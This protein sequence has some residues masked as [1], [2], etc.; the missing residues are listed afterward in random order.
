MPKTIEARLSKLGGGLNDGISAASIDLD[1]CSALRNFYPYKTDLKKRLGRK[2]LSD[3]SGSAIRGL[4]AYKRAVGEWRLLAADAAQKFL[5][6]VGDSFE[7]ID[8]PRES[9]KNGDFEQGLSGWT[10]ATSGTGAVTDYTGANVQFGAHCV[11]FTSTGGALNAAYAYQR[12]YPHNFGDKR[13]VRFW[14]KS[15]VG[16]LGLSLYYLTAA[17]TFDSQTV[18]LTTSWAEYELDWDFPNAEYAE[19]KF[20]WMQAGDAYV[21]E[22]TE[23]PLPRDSDE[24]WSFVQYLNTAY[25]VRPDRGG[26]LRIDGRGVHDAGI[27]APATAPTL[28]CYGS[29]GSVEEGDFQG[30]V[31][32][33][34]LDTDTESDPS[35][36][37]AVCTVSAADGRVTWSGIP[38]STSPQVNARRLYRTLP[39]QEG[40]Y[41]LVT[42]IRDN[43]TTVYEDELAIEELGAQASFNNGL[44]PTD[45]LKCLAIWRERLWA[46]SRTSLLF[47]EQFA[48]EGFKAS[49]EIQISPDDGHELVGAVPFGDRLC[50]AK[51]NS[52]GFILGNGPEDFNVRTFE[53][54]NGCIATSSLRS[55]EGLL[56]WY[57]GENVFMSDGNSVR[58]V[59]DPSIRG[60]LDSIPESEKRNVRGAIYPRLGWYLLAV[61]VDPPVE[62][63]NAIR[64]GGFELGVVADV[65]PQGIAVTNN[66]GHVEVVAGGFSGDYCLSIIDPPGPGNSAQV[67]WTYDVEAGDRLLSFWSKGAAWTFTLTS[68]GN[69]ILSESVP[70]STEWEKREYR[71]T[72]DADATVALLVVAGSTTTYLDDLTDRLVRK[73]DIIG[74]LLVF[75]YRENSWTTFDYAGEAPATMASFFDAELEGRIYA[76]FDSSFAVYDL[77]DPDQH[78]DDHET[79]AN[80]AIPAYPVVASFK[81]KAIDFGQPG[82]L[83]A[84]KRVQVLSN[85]TGQEAMW[86]LYRDLEES[87]SKERSLPLYSQQDRRWKTVSLSEMTRKAYQTQFELEEYGSLPLTIEAVSLDGTVWNWQEVQ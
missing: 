68:G 13:R 67:T 78:E 72:A 73:S 62:S 87:P 50:W 38:T 24:E 29:P 49:S 76:A 65:G 85:S 51:T 46:V 2:L 53:D 60:V 81:T 36:P 55:A 58:V 5:K 43:T 66:S 21:D 54:G 75:N 42:T 4:F 71:Y 35:D 70:S 19:I 86:R 22:V 83:H 33:V 48:P 3:G 63:V 61:K 8:Y 64:N 79:F 6:L 31:T 74:K 41:Y 80:G 18:L 20:E 30:V 44:P 52:V 28:T 39:N 9:V 10:V 23:G 84:I 32:F 26:I 57:S 37:S 25:A 47:S 45:D 15:S 56:F 40:E 77:T 14:A 82:R 12:L 59:S 17:G 11:K 27:A 34:N 1:E 69:T 16:G 7:R